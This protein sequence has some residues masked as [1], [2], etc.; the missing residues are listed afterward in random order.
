MRPSTAARARA[1]STYV[2]KAAAASGVNRGR[3]PYPRGLPWPKNSFGP[4]VA[5]TSGTDFLAGVLIGVPNQRRARSVREMLVHQG[6]EEC[7]REAYPGRPAAR[8][9]HR[10]PPTEL[11]TPFRRSQ[12]FLICQTD[13][14]HKPRRSKRSAHVGNRIWALFTGGVTAGRLSSQVHD[15]S[16]ARPRSRGGLARRRS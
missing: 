9:T 11:R 13:V 16:T 7:R 10:S 5:A 3:K 2:A 12:P 6:H 4:G 15:R 8:Q 14:I 1:A